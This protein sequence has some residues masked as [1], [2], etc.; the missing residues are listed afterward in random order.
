MCGDGAWGPQ[1]PCSITT[2]KKLRAIALQLPN[3]N[4]AKSNLGC[5]GMVLSED[6]N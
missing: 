4:I 2:Q 6:S 1:A 5:I 3:L